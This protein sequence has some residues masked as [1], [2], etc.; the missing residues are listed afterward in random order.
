MQLII[1]N[2]KVIATH[3]NSQKVAHLYPNT[4]C[5]K[6]EDEFE[7]GLFGDTS[8]PRTQQQKDNNYKDKRR[9]AYPSI[10]D[11]LDMMFNDLENGTT[12]WRDALNDIK[13]MYPKP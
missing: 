2:G 1:K 3:A 5:V 11:Q 8:D 9:V 12:T 4:E 10:E 6:W 7:L 13:I